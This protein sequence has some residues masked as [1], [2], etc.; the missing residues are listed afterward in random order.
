[1][2]VARFRRLVSLHGGR[3][4]AAKAKQQG[5][6]LGVDWL[7]FFGIDSS[8]KVP[9]RFFM[10]IACQSPFAGKQAVAR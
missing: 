10:S 9:E 4:G 6:R 3:L 8:L 2:C 5:R 1:M 7:P